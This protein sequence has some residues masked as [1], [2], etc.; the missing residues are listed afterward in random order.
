M[1]IQE[2]NDGALTS[3]LK[4]A[5]Y[6]YVIDM[7]NALPEEKAIYQQIKN[8]FEKNSFV[9]DAKSAEFF[10]F[11]LP[12]S[13]FNSDEV[14]FEPIN[15]K[16][17]EE[18]FP[19]DS[20]S[21]QQLEDIWR[22]GRFK[23][24]SLRCNMNYV[25]Q[26]SSMLVIGTEN[27]QKLFE[28]FEVSAAYL[29]C[30][31]P[32]MFDP[33]FVRDF[34]KHFEWPFPNFFKTVAALGSSVLTLVD[35]FIGLKKRIL[36]DSPE[37]IVVAF[38]NNFVNASKFE[39]KE[40]FPRNFNLALNLQEPLPLKI[41]GKSK[42]K[43]LLQN[44][45]LEQK[46]AYDTQMWKVNENQKQIRLAAKS[47]QEKW[48]QY[49][50]AELQN[51]PDCEPEE[52]A[53]RKRQLDARRDAFCFQQLKTALNIPEKGLLNDLIFKIE[54]LSV[55]KQCKADFEEEL[56][57]EQQRF[58]KEFSASH[59]ILSQVAFEREGRLD[60]FMLATT[61]QKQRKLESDI[62]SKL[63]SLAEEPY[64]FQVTEA[65]EKEF[66]HKL[67]FKRQEILK[68][69]KMPLETI[70]VT[71]RLLPPYRVV[72]YYVDNDD[73]P[74]F[75]FERYSVVKVSSR[76]VFWRWAAFGA[77]WASMTIECVGHLFRYL[78]V[79][80]FGLKGLLYWQ[81]YFTDYSIN[82]KTGEVR[83]DVHKV[84][85][86]AAKFTHVLEGIQR[87][88]QNFEEQPDTGIFGKR[89]SRAVN[90]VECYVLRLFVVGVLILLILHPL[91]NLLV[92]ALTALLCATA[93]AWVFAWLLICSVFRLLVFNYER[94]HNR[95]Y[96]ICYGFY[97]QLIETYTYFPLIQW[98][99]SLLFKGVLQLLLVVLLIV[100]FPTLALL[101]LIIGALVFLLRSGYDLLLY[102]A[103]VKPL[104]RV[105]QRNTLLAQKVSGPGISED[106]F[107]T[108]PKE[109]VG[110]L[111]IAELERQ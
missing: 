98:A 54:S 88:R 51:M 18:V 83:N 96:F 57:R 91:F 13:N 72:E 56:R 102:Y 69:L 73:K 80:E 65:R 53:E 15:I 36:F 78:C 79:G 68:A 48:Q 2:I 92:I 45:W 93:V 7:E 33:R 44:Q 95:R 43:Q 32:L 109:D 16:R 103:V 61:A 19:R 27:R 70:V 30:F 29:C 10:Q 107:F 8:Y 90:L 40:Q 52:F 82:E 6:Q 101:I 46:K 59:P 17:F 60:K 67:D 77:A 31:L 58:L 1:S 9:W 34:D 85:P 100:L 66:N 62:Q 94:M 3:A 105:P 50:D 76:F 110:T 63:V 84:S 25:W 97:D 55:F 74:R 99:I 87:S 39:L 106:L 42:R 12:P 4:K 26:L 49:Y 64:L 47:A 11:S 22:N 28:K 23:V 24:K 111:L 71:R 89:F 14:F 5:P 20:L 86:I 104:A 37:A 108:L 38:R 21:P 81:D 35:L 75:K 41:A